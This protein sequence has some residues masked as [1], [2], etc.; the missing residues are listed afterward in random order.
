LHKSAHFAVA[1]CIEKDGGVRYVGFRRLH[2]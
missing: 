1:A 2:V